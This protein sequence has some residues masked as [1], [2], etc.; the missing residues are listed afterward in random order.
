MLSGIGPEPELKKLN[1]E[2][3]QNL[4]VGKNLHDHYSCTFDFRLRNPEQW[5]VMGSE[6]FNKNPNH[7]KGNPV[8]WLISFPTSD[9]LKEAAAKIDGDELDLGPRSDVEVFCYPAC[10]GGAVGPL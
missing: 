10:I 6:G 5:Q 9:D 1:I 7:L 3:V 2:L 8:N 4:P